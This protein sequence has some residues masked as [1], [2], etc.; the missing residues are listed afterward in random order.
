MNLMSVMTAFQPYL[1]VD[2]RFVKGEAGAV[3]S[4]RVDVCQ[5]NGEEGGGFPVP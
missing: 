1:Q 4:V 2:L 5:D 3:V